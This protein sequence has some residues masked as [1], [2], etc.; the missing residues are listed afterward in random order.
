MR[1]A[2]TPAV[3][4]T[5]GV[6]RAYIA[7][8]NAALAIARATRPK[9]EGDKTTDVKLEPAAPALVEKKDDHI[10]KGLSGIGR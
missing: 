2:R 1:V 9:A 6:G 4:L 7:K 10:E 5:C 3:W 8:R